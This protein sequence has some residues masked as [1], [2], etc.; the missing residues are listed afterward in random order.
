MSDLEDHFAELHN[1]PSLSEGSEGGGL[2]PPETFSTRHYLIR[3]LPEN[4]EMWGRQ[5]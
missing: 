1:P 4:R 2:N 5:A 3:G